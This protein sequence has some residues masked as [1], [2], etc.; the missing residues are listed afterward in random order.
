MDR[1]NLL[2]I[3]S[4]EKTDADINYGRIDKQKLSALSR[5]IPFRT[6]KSI[7]LCGPE[8][9]IFASAAFL[10]ELGIDK[11]SIHFE[12]FTIPGQ[13]AS[14]K[15]TQVVDEEKATGPES[16]ISIKLDGRTFDF[17]LSFNG[18]SI[19]DKA[20]QLGADLPYAC[21][22]G[23]CCSCKAKLIQG[24]VEMDVNY[25]LEPEEVKEGFILA[26]QSH[27]RSEKIVIDFDIK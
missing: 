5:L 3:L 8:E 1:F 14:Q 13:A 17:G 22:G 7:Y 11:A 4:R 27:P 10:E 2:Y 23:V 16:Q 18:Q 24:K 15:I 26:C 19:L 6:F 20:L 9:M 21:K 12:L 25:A